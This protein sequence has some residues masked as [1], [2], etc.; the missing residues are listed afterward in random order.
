[1]PKIKMAL[2]DKI[3]EVML[4]MFLI[5]FSITTLYPFFYV[6][7][8]SL[9]SNEVPMTNLYFIPQKM[10]LEGYIKV[11][12]DENIGLGFKNAVIRTV[13]GTI[14]VVI[15]TTAF[16]YPLS[17]K[18]FPHRKFWTAVVVFTMYFHG[19]MI[20]DYLLVKQL[21][22]YNTMWALILPHLMSIFH[23]LIVRNFFMT[24]PESLEESAMIDGA[25]EIVV[26][27]RIIIPL[28]LPIIATLTLWSAVW[29]WNEW[30]MA[31]IYIQDAKKQV[32]QNI[33]RNIVMEG[34]SP[35]ISE[36]NPD[37]VVSHENVKAATIMIT[38]LPIVIVYPFVQKYFVKGV[39]IG[40]V[41]S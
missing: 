10:S 14:L 33:M 22:I 1:M 7:M 5:A 35:M 39:M 15:V 24:I 32:I 34:M 28:S 13:T 25:N 26:L 41:K 30:F 11:L 3:F 16:A 9:A 18:Y 38:T 40:S 12:S 21:G 20:P 6:L 31:L 8:G 27:V 37:K 4:Y 17:K 36:A 29:H 23:L 2:G 19:G